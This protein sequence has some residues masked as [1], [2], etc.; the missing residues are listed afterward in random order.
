MIMTKEQAL[1]ASRRTIIDVLEG[2]ISRK[3]TPSRYDDQ[4]FPALAVEYVEQE[5]P[6]WL[7]ERLEDPRY[8]LDGKLEVILYLHDDLA[9]RGRRLV[10]F[11]GTADEFHDY[12]IGILGVP[13]L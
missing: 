1:D 13:E 4:N 8:G 12:A 11:Q 5:D 7:G 9:E 6:R 10:G 2:R 3:K